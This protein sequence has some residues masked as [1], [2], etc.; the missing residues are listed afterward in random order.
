MFLKQFVVCY[1][2]LCYYMFGYCKMSTFHKLLAQCLHLYCP[3]KFCRC[4]LEL[5][6]DFSSS[7]GCRYVVLGI[8]R[9]HG[10]VETIVYLL[11][12]TLAAG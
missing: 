4:G 1:D 10:T 5:T 9:L 6:C 2:I 12:S 7:Q 11:L 3:V 8:Y